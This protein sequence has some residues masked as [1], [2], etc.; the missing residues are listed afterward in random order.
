MS[1]A[2]RSRWQYQTPH[3][4]RRSNIDRVLPDES[5]SSYPESARHN[6][7]VFK[8]LSS[9]IEKL[10]ANF[11]KLVKGIVT[12]L[13]TPVLFFP[14][15]CLKA[16]AQS[17][18]RLLEMAVRPTWPII[19]RI[20]NLVAI[21]VPAIM[22]VTPYILGL[23]GLLQDNPFVHMGLSASF[24]VSLAAGLGVSLVWKIIAGMC[25]PADNESLKSS[26]LMSWIMR[27]TRGAGFL[28]RLLSTYGSA[29]SVGMLMASWLRSL[30]IPGLY[31]IL[32][33]ALGSIG[34]LYCFRWITNYCY[35]DFLSSKS[36]DAS[37]T[38]HKLSFLLLDLWQLLP[39]YVA[40][41][42]VMMV[43]VLAYNMSE[44]I[45]KLEVSTYYQHHA[46]NNIDPFL[47]LCVIGGFLGGIS[48]GLALGV[49]CITLTL[50]NYSCRYQQLSSKTALTITTL[51]YIGMVVNLMGC[52]Q[53]WVTLFSLPSSVW[54][55]ISGLGCCLANYCCFFYDLARAVSRPKGQVAVPEYMA[56]IQPGIYALMEQ[57]VCRV[58]LFYR[59]LANWCDASLSTKPALKA[60]CVDWRLVSA[61]S[62]PS[63]VN[64][65]SGRVYEL[66]QKSA[67]QKQ[68]DT[69]VDLSLLD[70]FKKGLFSQPSEV[71][72]TQNLLDEICHRL[73]RESI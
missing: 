12:A 73:D 42:P 13:L 69:A 1:Q 7:S 6:K 15:S 71:P 4:A 23:S 17:A 16:L 34:W 65:E 45:K 43:S 58:Y 47:C 54:I 60:W 29:L 72:S 2:Y 40:P 37:K 59:A 68:V 55:G 38:K 39:L 10:F 19:T 53:L 70:L 66:T 5:H 63:R 50:S 33:G 67:I 46:N 32:F 28:I 62:L 8:T 51:N 14:L 25:L 30:A 57:W 9:A 36:N 61:H 64:L 41:Y 22:R 52:F 21:G 31:G 49:A 24:S 18:L 3:H 11:Y 44:W 27:E 48:P 20:G 26:R 35:P 56:R